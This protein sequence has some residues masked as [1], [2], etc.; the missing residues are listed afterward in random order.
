MYKFVKS[1]WERAS[2]EQRILVS[3]LLLLLLLSGI[4]LL[5]IEPFLEYRRALVKEYEK[6][7]LLYEKYREKAQKLPQLKEE[8]K[9][10]NEEFAK[11]KGRFFTE[12]TEILAFSVFKDR[13]SALAKDRGVAEEGINQLSSLDIGGV[14]K[15]RL[16]GRYKTEDL[17]SLLNFMLS[18]ERGD[19]LMGFESVDIL[20][21]TYRGKK[22]YYLQAEIYGLWI[23]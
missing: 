23:H 22:T 20:L 10:V 1:A 18:V 12:E 6:Q 15:L 21:D 7:K 13:L 16:R 2:R 4:Y 19:K 11:V 14:T 3:S 17:K 8:L 9:K 5:A